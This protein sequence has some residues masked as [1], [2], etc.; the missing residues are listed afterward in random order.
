[1]GQKGHSPPHL[2]QVVGTPK[3]GMVALYLLGKVAA[4]VEHLL[5]TPYRLRCLLDRYQ[6]RAR[7]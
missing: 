5:A 3:I 7:F 2:L 1:M 6:R 4:V